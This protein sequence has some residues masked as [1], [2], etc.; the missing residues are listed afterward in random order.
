MAGDLLVRLLYV[1]TEHNP[2]D[3]PSRGVRRRPTTRLVRH[4][5]HDERLM[6]KKVR[7]H[8]RLAGEIERSPYS[9]ELADLVSKDPLFW[10]FHQ[11]GKHRARGL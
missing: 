3:G 4:K 6:S 5:L 1:P 10:N 2:A 11:Q 9:A 7:Y 8:K